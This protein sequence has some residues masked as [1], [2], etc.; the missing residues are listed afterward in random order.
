MVFGR[1]S[2]KLVYQ[3]Q[4]DISNYRR[5]M[6][7]VRKDMDGTTTSTEQAAGGF[8]K[9]NRAMSVFLASAAVAQVG[10]FAFDIAKMGQNAEKAGQAAEKVLGPALEGLEDNLDNIRKSA[11][12]SVGEFSGLLAQMGL[13]TETLVDSDQAQAKYIEKMIR[14]A[15]ALAQFNPH[16]GDTADALEAIF[17]GLK[18]NFNPLE[19][20]GL[21][22]KKVQI[23]ERAE[24]LQDL[25]AALSDSEAEFLAFIEIVEEQGTPAM[26]EFDENLETVQTEANELSAE[27]K[28]FKEILGTVVA[29]AVQFLVGLMVSLLGGLFKVR[30]FLGGGGWRDAW[31]KFTEPP[32]RMIAD[33]GAA[34]DRFIGRI[35]SAK[36]AISGIRFP[37]VP[38]FFKS[39]TGRF[40]KGGTVPGPR[41]QPTGIIA[42]GGERISSLGGGGGMEGISI[43]I[44]TGVGDPQEIARQIVELL[45][46]Y[47]RGNGALPI[48]VGGFR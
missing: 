6:Q 7:Q 41:G 19:Q 45:Q 37:S 1:S 21:K 38:S 11:G 26:E 16:G 43:T 32:R 24:E 29:P 13:M 31:A 2:Q 39:F 14:M 17:S 42:H 3:V 46:V 8:G 35:S 4:A 28:T 34:W 20:F 48:D 44:N 12:L 27:F 18:N 5:G 36:K 47:Q 40:A 33:L 23:N 25:N 10:R 22:L 15:A 30:A 9:M